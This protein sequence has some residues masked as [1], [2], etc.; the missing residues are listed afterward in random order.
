[1]TIKGTIDPV[2]AATIVLTREHQGAL[3]IYLLKRS[4]GSSFMG[5]F[6]VFPGGRVDEED[7]DVDFWRSHADMNALSKIARGTL[8]VE[9][10]VCY[11][12]AAIRE[13]FEEAG[14]LLA[15]RP[16]PAKLESRIAAMWL[17]SG[18]LK[19][20][21]LRACA[22]KNGWFPDFSALLPW[23]HWITPVLM[24][25]RFDTRFFIVNIPEGMTC[26]PDR[27]ETTHGLWISPE[28]GL[29]ENMA[30]RIP[31]SPPTLVTLQG[32]I[33]FKTFDQV[34]KGSLANGW[35]HPLLPRLVVLE[36]EAIILEPWDPCYLDDD[37]TIDRATLA[38]SV[39]GVGEPFSRLWN[40]EGPWK[41][42]GCPGL[43]CGG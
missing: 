37:V 2:P 11:A 14:A 9:E 21:W 3:Q 29:A 26:S 43:D 6:Y 23:S 5:G 35:G 22:A 18:D 13:T 42:V 27:S 25:R 30:G 17:R 31:L 34:K 7:R 28:K 24:K 32:L 38:G 40:G 12:V 1:M 20:G 8:A 19:P 16:A 15:D 4:A 41:P 39:L 10:A 36:N 33:G